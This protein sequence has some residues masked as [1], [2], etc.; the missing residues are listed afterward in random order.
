VEI[1]AAADFM[2]SIVSPLSNSY[3]S[4]LVSFGFC[5]YSQRFAVG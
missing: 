3:Q 4:A 5:P 1:A 2:H